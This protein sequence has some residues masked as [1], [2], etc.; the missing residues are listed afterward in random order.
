MP[1]KSKL[2]AIVAYAAI[3]VGVFSAIGGVFGLSYTYSQAA[4]ERITTPEDARIAEKPVRGPLTMWSQADIV[5]T[6]QLNR[7]EGLR[8]AEMPRQIEQLDE[9]GAPVLGED[10][11]PVMVP[12]QARLSWLDATT[13]ITSLSL[14]MISYAFSLFALVVGLVFLGMGLVILKLEK[15]VVA[16]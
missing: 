14:G 4:A 1:A 3:V 13:I 15:A 5:T 10:G 16:V 6:H 11:M 12:N 9:N 7:T 8:Y 2:F